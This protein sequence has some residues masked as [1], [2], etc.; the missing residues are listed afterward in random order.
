[1]GERRGVEGRAR[2]SVVGTRIAEGTDENAVHR[3]ARIDP[4]SPHA[5]QAE[6]SAHRLGQVGGDRGCLGRNVEW[7]RA[8]DLVP[9]TGDRLVARRD[10]AE[11]RVKEGVV[12]GT[13]RARRRKNA[14]ER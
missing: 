10:H 7:N 14:P 13:C 6:R 2:R 5:S 9:T 8:P 4:Q 11:E 3:D 12:P 1:M